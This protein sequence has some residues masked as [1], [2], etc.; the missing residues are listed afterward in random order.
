[1]DYHFV[2]EWKFEAPLELVWKEIYESENWPQWWKGVLSVDHL[3]SGDENGIGDRK[4]YVWRSFL[5]YNLSFES[6]LVE[7][8]LHRKLAGNV[9][10]ELEGSGVWTFEEQDGYTCV[11]YDWQV[12]TTKR[13]MNFLAPIA[14]PFFEWNH[15][16]VM[17]W[18]R[19][20]LEKRLF[21][22]QL[23]LKMN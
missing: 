8:M 23:L 12:R 21:E 1:M 10:G 15:N 7:K 14:K 20:A 19:V 18:G 9:T 5:P 3:E 2:T 11:R 13:W 16:V 17:E 6:K 22:N 4:K